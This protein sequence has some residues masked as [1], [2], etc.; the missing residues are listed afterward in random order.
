MSVYDNIDS[1]AKQKG[2]S[3][4]QLAKL[5][6]ISYSTLAS[7]FSR[8]PEVFPLKYAEAIA[9]A[10][11]VSLDMLYGKPRIKLKLQAINDFADLVKDACKRQETVLDIFNSLN[12]TGQLTMI[13]RGNELRELPRYT[14][15][16][17]E[18]TIEWTYT[19]GEGLEEHFPKDRNQ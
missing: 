15:P 10:L 6:G 19:N 13:E 18:G 5:S 3:R 11:G 1:L 17:D 7:C 8:K 14:T 9:T 12:L 2:I 16:D 4:R